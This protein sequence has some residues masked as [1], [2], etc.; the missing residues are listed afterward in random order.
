VSLAAEA[1]DP[2]TRPELT[3]RMRLARRL[4]L[5]AWRLA[6]ALGLFGRQTERLRAALA[7]GA[8]AT[9]VFTP[10][11]I[12]LLEPPAHH[13]ASMQRLERTGRC[14]VREVDVDHSML[15]PLGREET[16]RLLTGHLLGRY[17]RP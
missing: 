4:P 9:I 11:D 17:A 16:L 7:A 12:V 10:G 3:G 8:R 2:E 5:W 13:V 6:Y 15:D 14:T 1:A